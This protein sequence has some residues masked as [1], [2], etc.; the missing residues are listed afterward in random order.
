MREAQHCEKLFNVR[1]VTHLL[2]VSITT[3]LVTAQE[4]FLT[5]KDLLRKQPK[6]VASYLKFTDRD[7]HLLSQ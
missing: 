6:G 3:F 1:L 4:F 7:K 5:V 2:V